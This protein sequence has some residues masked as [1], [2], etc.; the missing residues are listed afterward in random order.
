MLG[1]ESPGG[2]YPVMK[3]WEGGKFQFGKAFGVGGGVIA[4]GEQEEEGAVR[5]DAAG[6]VPVRGISHFNT[7]LLFSRGFSKI[8]K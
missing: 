4:R 3:K 6:H 7:K 1:T 8:R 2:G 5:R